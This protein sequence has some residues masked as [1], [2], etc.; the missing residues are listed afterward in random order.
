M[1]DEKSTCPGVPK[2]LA[3]YEGDDD[4]QQAAVLRQVLELHPDVLARGELIREMTGG[5]SQG[6][7]DVDAVERA[8]RDLTR[9]GLLHLAASED[10][11]VRPTRAAVR[12]FELTGGA[13]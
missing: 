12:Y 6:F 11:I 10:D 7:G 13:Y 4:R 5:G 3:A 1:A 2:C 9:S 8:I